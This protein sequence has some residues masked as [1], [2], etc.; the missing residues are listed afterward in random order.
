MVLVTLNLCF[1]NIIKNQICS[2]IPT[3]NLK[4]AQSE[5]KTFSKLV[6]LGELTKSNDVSLLVLIDRDELNQNISKMT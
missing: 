2:P 3:I 4:Y 1:C 5:S 6:T